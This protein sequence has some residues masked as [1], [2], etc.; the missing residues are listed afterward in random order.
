MRERLAYGAPAFALALFGVPVFVHLPKFYADV[1][2]I[3]LGTLGVAILLTRSWDALLDPVIGVLSDRTRSRW[4]RRRPYLMFAP[5]PLALAVLLLFAPP[6][7]SGVGWF[8]GTMTMA[9]L[10]WTLVQIPHAALG[11]E[12]TADH[13]A[14]TSLFAWRDGLWIAGTLAAAAGPAIVGSLT[15]GGTGPEDARTTFAILGAAYAVLLVALPWTCA[16]VV[17]EHYV[18]PSATGQVLNSKRHAIREALANR[19]FRLLLAAYAVGALGGALPGTLLFFYVEHVLRAPDQADLF[20][21]LYFLSGFLCLP[22][23]TAIARRAGKKEA[24]VAAMLMSVGVFSGAFFLGPGDTSWF[25]AIVVLSGAGFGASL[26]LPASMQAD[27]IDLDELESGT[28]REGLFLGLWSVMTKASAAV[29]AGAAL[30]ILGAAGYVAG[31]PQNA[32]VVLALRV[33]YCLV[34]CACYAAALLI[35]IRYPLDEAAHAE[36]RAALDRR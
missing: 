36:I 25:T 32:D 26:A 18:A 10:A 12:L 21:G 27:T 3:P 2:G 34:P 9:F 17:R 8:A 1:V 7:G 24:F 16:Y 14:R 30:P 11:P 33:M 35:V 28:R 23:W 15:G 22:L 20:L 13:H 29:G 31:A 4:G 19:P 5:V 6:E